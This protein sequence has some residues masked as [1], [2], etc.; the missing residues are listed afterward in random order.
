MSEVFREF[1]AARRQFVLINGNV[2]PIPALYAAHTYMVPGLHDVY[3]PTEHEDDTPSLELDGQLVPGT[4]VLTDLYRT[5][6]SGGRVQ[7][8]DAS[9]AVRVILG[10]NPMGHATSKVYE[11]GLTLLPD[12]IKT[13]EGLEKFR[14][15]AKKR[16]LRWRIDQA[17]EVVKVIDDR[18]FKLERQGLPVMPGGHEYRTALMLLKT[19]AEQDQLLSNQIL[20]IDP[21]APPPQ[22]PL[23]NTEEDEILDFIKSKV[24]TAAPEKTTEEK[25]LLVEKLLKDPEALKMLDKLRKRRAAFGEKAT[26]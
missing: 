7:R 8:L 18:N 20:G 22:R 11:R 17:R 3:E 25:A 2:D 26:L 21:L 24:D 9:D 13:R 19:E 16:A 14:E 23:D 5:D 15:A 10:I 12:S 4:L 1:T 6:A